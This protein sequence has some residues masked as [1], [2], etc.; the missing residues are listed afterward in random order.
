MPLPDRDR[1]MSW[2]RGPWK[3]RLTE[4]RGLQ[5][6]KERARGRGFTGAVWR[7]GFGSGLGA[8]P[9]GGGG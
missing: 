3:R 5:G 7:R 4:Q 9:V 2:G 6:P 8:W 1:E